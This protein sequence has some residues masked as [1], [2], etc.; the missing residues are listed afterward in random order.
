[1]RGKEELLVTP[2]RISQ[3]GIYEKRWRSP[4]SKRRMVSFIIGAKQG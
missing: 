1:M 4:D 2:D 3:S